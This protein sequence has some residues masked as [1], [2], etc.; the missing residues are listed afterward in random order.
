MDE[1][2]FYPMSEKPSSDESDT[3]FSTTV[4]I[5]NEKYSAVGLGYYDF[6]IGEWLHFSHNS[7]LL[8]CWCYIPVPKTEE[9]KNWE[10]IAPRGYL[11]SLF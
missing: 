9:D 11:K 8:K 1:T 2:K 10:A 6:E 4:I 3:S 5:Y 7:F